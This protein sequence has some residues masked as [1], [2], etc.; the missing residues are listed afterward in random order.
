MLE[1]RDLRFQTEN[2]VTILSLCMFVAASLLSTE[3]YLASTLP[4][5]FIFDLKT[6]QNTILFTI[7]LVSFTQK[8]GL[9]CIIRT[10]LKSQTVFEMKNNY[11]KSKKVLFYRE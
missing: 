4:T 11:G 10:N 1:Q 6:K 9:Y 8:K 7:C 2:T 5:A 3:C